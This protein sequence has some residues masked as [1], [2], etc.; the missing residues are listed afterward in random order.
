MKYIILLI[1]SFYSFSCNTEEGSY[2]KNINSDNNNTQII[3]IGA[4][5][6]E[7]ENGRIYINGLL[8]DTLPVRFMIDNGSPELSLDSTLIAENPYLNIKVADDV[9][10]DLQTP[11]G[12]IQGQICT[13]DLRFSIDDWKQKFGMGFITNKK[14][15]FYADSIVGA[16]PMHMLR[17]KK[18][19]EINLK[20]KYINSHD[21][22]DLTDFIKIPFQSAQSKAF[23]INTALVLKTGQ[24]MVNLKGY[25]LVDYGDPRKEVIINSNRSNIQGFKLDTITAYDIINFK[26]VSTSYSFICDTIQFNSIANTCFTNTPI[27]IENLDKNHPEGFGGVVGVKFLEHFN[28]VIDYEEKM[29]YLKP[30]DKMFTISKEN[31]I[32]KWGIRVY[33]EQCLSDPDIMHKWLVSKIIRG[34]EADK[35][36]VGLTDEVISINGVSTQ[37]LAISNG[38]KLLDLA[39]EIEIKTKE[40]KIIKLRDIN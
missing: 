31:T 13:G 18:L 28:V 39:K 3:P 24:K 38:R 5:P 2:K 15:F 16:L 6:I 8:N 32:K 35:Q 34:K 26:K 9:I 25:F 17:Q 10:L 36:R 7:Y 23:I 37:N 11:M 22:L 1:L 30:Y 19:L 40:N 29:L 33:P 4:L 27:L 12:K 14:R 21:S 20:N